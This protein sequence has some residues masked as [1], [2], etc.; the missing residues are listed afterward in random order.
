M[1]QMDWGYK[2]SNQ[3]REALVPQR[4]NHIPLWKMEYQDQPRPN[5]RQSP[6]SGSITNEKFP[7]QFTHS[8]WND[9]YVDLLSTHTEATFSTKGH[10][11]PQTSSPSSII[12]TRRGEWKPSSQLTLPTQANEHGSQSISCLAGRESHYHA[13]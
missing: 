7:G 11:Q 5:I 10:Q 2:N 12:S 9:Q 1:G 8:C 13:P 6:H 3:D 4:N